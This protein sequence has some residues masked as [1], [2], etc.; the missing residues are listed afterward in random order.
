MN[1][2]RPPSHTP[3]RATRW[4]DALAVYLE[5]RVLIL[6]AMGF[7][8]GLP[9]LLVFGTLSFWLREADVSLT[10]I[11]YMSWV[12]LAYGFKW[13]WSPLVDRLPLP[14]LSRLLGRRRSLMCV[15]VGG[16]EC[17]LDGEVR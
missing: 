17:S 5:A 10:D 1:N 9:L 6:F 4:R 13:I 2:L 7:S 15:N 3:D 11:G 8:S 14:L 12:A 16:R